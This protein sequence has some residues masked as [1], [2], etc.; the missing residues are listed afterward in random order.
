MTTGRLFGTDGIRGRAFEE[1]L[2]EDTVRRVGVALAEELADQC[3]QPRILLAGDT[4]ASTAM[5]AG[6]LGSSFQAAG[7]SVV[8]GGVLPTPAV[9]HLL[10]GSNCVAGV[11]ISASHN[12]AE[13]NGIKILSPLG[14]KLADEHERRLEQRVREARPAAGPELPAQ[15]PTLGD[16]YLAHLAASHET[17]EALRGL[18]L[19]VD[20]ANGAASGLARQLLEILGAKVNVTAASPD[21]KNINAGCGT[22]NPAGLARQVVELGADGGLAVDGDADRAILVDEGGRVLD[23]DD[24]LLAWARQLQAEDRLPS[25]RVVATVMSNF[26]LESALQAEGMT[27]VRCPVGDRAVWIAMNEHGAVLGGEQSGHVICSHYGVSGDGLLTGT[28]VLAIAAR[29]GIPVSAL[30]DLR[31]LPQV[32]LNVPVS[33]RAQFEDLPSVSRE[34]ARTQRYLAGR[35]RVVLRYSGTEAL[36]RVMVEGESAPEIEDHAERIAEAIRK[37]LR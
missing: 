12:P 30:S 4:R 24:I 19:V 36:A 33:R 32:L 7:G 17:R 2:D 28:H 15:D 13:D 23:G 20:A 1:P 21:G 34:L 27:V 5:L 3:P 14:E 37:E 25:G 31:R 11:V 16:R 8:W 35:G 26:G 18:H 22:T 6:W 10:R 29:R 9:S